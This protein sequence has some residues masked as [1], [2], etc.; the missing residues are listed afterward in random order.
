MAQSK[1][2][3][4]KGRLNAA[5]VAEGINAAIENAKRLADDAALLLEAGRFPTAASLAALAIEEA[6]KDA[7]LRQLALAHDD[8]G[9][10]EAWRE[11]RSHTRKNVMWVF[12]D[13]VASGARKL[14]DFAP[15]FD[16]TSDHP[17]VLDQV[18]QLGFYTDCL[19]KA[20]WSCPAIVV[21][22][23]LAHALVR[24]AKVLSSSTDTVTVR[25]IEL[26][27]EHLGPVWSRHPSWR[28]RALENCQGGP[29]RFF[30]VKVNSSSRCRSM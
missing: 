21:N 10:A 3:Q 26:W 17:D 20:H 16:P 2:G 8:K 11:Y 4:Y 9:A 15:I 13:L 23:G 6:G 25:E 27:I 29:G 7:I 5:Q 12:V 28:E 22:E 19:G 30:G 18:K 1:L 14:D 24:T